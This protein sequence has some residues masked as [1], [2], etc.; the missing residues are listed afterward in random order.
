MPHLNADA[1]HHILL[2]YQPGVRG[3]GFKALAV[4]H[5][6]RGGATEL[7]EWHRR[8]DGT[9]RSL[10]EKKRSGRPPLLSA[11]EVQRHIAAP[12]RREN[13]AARQVRYTKL[14]A[15]LRERTGKNVSDRTVQRIGK[16]QLGAKKTRG[17][18]RTA[19]ERQCTETW[20]NAS[21]LV[22]SVQ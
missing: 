4:R 5:G 12:I 15:C 9:A 18:K 17:K 20:G 19:E 11:V 14:A 2:E 13:H 10:K 1:K 16:E 6:I 8:W 7:S 21:S 22:Y 3:S